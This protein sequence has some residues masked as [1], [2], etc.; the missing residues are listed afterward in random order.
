MRT[1]TSPLDLKTALDNKEQEVLWDERNVYL[2]YSRKDVQEAIEQ[3][4][5]HIYPGNKRMKTALDVIAKHQDE[6][7]LSDESN[8]ITGPILVALST[9]FVVLVL[10]LVA[11]LKNTHTTLQYNPKDGTFEL[12]TY[13]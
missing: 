9:L 1:I 6:L 8:S 11:L 5:V 3:S 10:G 13:R 12:I 4:K 7:V 2:V